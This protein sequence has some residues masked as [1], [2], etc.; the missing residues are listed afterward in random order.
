MSLFMDYY[1][2]QWMI[3]NPDADFYPLD[4]NPAI[5]SYSA[6]IHVWVFQ[7]PFF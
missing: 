6:N 2:L 1:G 5:V 4:E 3:M 7:N